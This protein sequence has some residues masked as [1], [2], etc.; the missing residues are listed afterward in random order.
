MKTY[1]KKLSKTDIGVRLS[2]PTECFNEH[3][4][5]LCDEKGAKGQGWFEATEDIN[6]QKKWKFHLSTRKASHSHPKPV[7]SAGWLPY[8]RAKRLRE[9]DQIIFHVHKKGGQTRFT[10]QALRN[11]KLFGAQIWNNVEDFNPADAS[12]SILS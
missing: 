6:T 5:T 1:R 3:F 7:I 9:G 12:S 2:F 4:A 11:F 8:V 10:I